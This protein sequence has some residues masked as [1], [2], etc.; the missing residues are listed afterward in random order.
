MSTE[1]DI[2]AK[3]RE[4]FIDSGR[5]RRYHV[6]SYIF[7]MQGLEFCFA[8]IGAKRHVTGRELSRS[9]AQFA[10]RQFGPLAFQVLLAWGVS[11]SADFGF[12][13]Y[14]LI[15]LGVMS[16]TESDALEDFFNVLDLKDY[17][18]SIDYYPIDKKY[19]GMLQGA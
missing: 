18:A 16:K 4:A 17:F 3:I 14:N 11:T 19:L 15:E 2:T 9:L 13:V 8:K 10:H 1:Q 6:A 5:D 12:I 7:V